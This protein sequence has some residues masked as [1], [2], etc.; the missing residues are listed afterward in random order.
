MDAV[1]FPSS[2]FAGGG[3][4]RCA[5]AFLGGRCQVRR[6]FGFSCET[7]ESPPKYMR[8]RELPDWPLTTEEG[9]TKIGAGLCTSHPRNKK[10]SA[11]DILNN[12]AWRFGMAG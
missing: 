2:S 9:A 3:S 5:P 4:K 8:V 6:G 12:V 11:N 1:S 7:P 10:C